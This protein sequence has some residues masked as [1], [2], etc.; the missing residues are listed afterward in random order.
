[1][2]YK[3]GIIIPSTSRKRPWSNILESYLYTHLIRSLLK[4]YNSEHEYKIY[5]VTD[6]DDPIYSKK[7]EIH[8]MRLLG[9]TQLFIKL[10]Y[11]IEGMILGSVGALISMSILYSLY[12]ISVYIIEPYYLV[13]SFFTVNI[14]IFN[15]ILV[16]LLG[17]VY[18]IGYGS[19]VMMRPIS[20]KVS[21]SFVGGVVLP[22]CPFLSRRMCRK[23]SRHSVSSQRINY[24]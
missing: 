10:P 22:P 14:L 2:P 20:Q 15:L 23:Q 8:T 18:A 16:L 1:M 3:I 5:V 21:C 7:D 17:L 6:D 4:T 19:L 9:A 12:K 11:I 13:P 24:K